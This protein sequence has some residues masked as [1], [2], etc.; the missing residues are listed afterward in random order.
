MQTVSQPGLQFTLSHHHSDEGIPYQLLSIALTRPDR[1]LYPADLTQL[2]LPE[3]IDPGKGIVLSGRGPLWLYGHLIHELHPT[4]WVACYDPRLGAV[5]VASHSPLVRVGQVIALKKKL[6]IPPCEPLCPALM[7]VGPPDSGKSIFAH[8][9]FNALLPDYPDI[10][11]QRAHWDGEGNWILDAGNGLTEAEREEFKLV[12]RG[13]LT[14][15][16][17][18]YHYE[19]ILNLRRQK[20]LVIV[21]VGGKVQ[22]EKIP[23]LEACSHYLVISSNADEVQPWHEFCH[24]RGNLKLIAVIQSSLPLVEQIEQREPYLIL[25]TAACVNG[26]PCPVPKPLLEQVHQLLIN[27]TSIIS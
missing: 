24:D 15:G 20:Q 1:L 21:D 4:A 8:A 13:T 14:P 12:Y 22:P 23:L 7:I 18:P 6:G 17:F 9:L 26:K 16:F 10:Y 2:Q 11:L 25:T 19:A 5:V 27:P 3:N